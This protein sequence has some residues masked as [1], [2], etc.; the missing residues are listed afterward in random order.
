MV[1]LKV[2]D[3]VW[4]KVGSAYHRES[5]YPKGPM[6]VRVTCVLSGDSFDAIPVNKDL[7]QISFN[8]GTDEIIRRKPNIH[9]KGR[10]IGKAEVYQS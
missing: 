9:R 1:N 5:G 2:G 10:L 8:Y 3:I 6:Q 4:I 7:C